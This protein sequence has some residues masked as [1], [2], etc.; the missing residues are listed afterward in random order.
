MSDFR[1][2]WVSLHREQNA[3]VPIPKYDALPDNSKKSTEICIIGGGIF[4]LSCALRLQQQGHQ[5]VLIEGRRIGS[6]TTGNSTGKLCLDHNKGKYQ[7][8]I[9]NFGV[10]HAKTYCD[11]NIEGMRFVRECLSKYEMEC[12]YEQKDNFTF[13]FTEEE[14][15]QLKR[16]VEALHKIGVRG[17]AFL[18]PDALPH[19]K[20]LNYGAMRVKR[21]AQMNPYGFCVKMA[22][23]FVKEGGVIHE[24]TRAVN[25]SKGAAP[26]TVTLSNGAEVSASKAVIV[27][28]HL[29]I[30]DRS[31][32]WAS[33][34]P[35]ASYGIA[36]PVNQKNEFHPITEMHINSGASGPAATKSFRVAGGGKYMVVVGSSHAMGEES[37]ILDMDPYDNLESFAKKY[38]NVDTDSE[39]VGKWFAFDYA[40][41]DDLGPYIGYLHLG[42]KSLF[43]ATGFNKWGLS[44]GAGASEYVCQLIEKGPDD[45][46]ESPYDIFDARRFD[47]KHSKAWCFG[48]NVARHFIGD[49]I[50]D[51]FGEHK[52]VDE[53]PPG[54]GGLY[55]YEN[56]TRACY[57]D[58]SGKLTVT[59]L[60]CQHLKCHVRY[61]RHTRSLCC[62][63]HGSH[64]N[65]KGEVLDAP[66]VK[67]LRTILCDIEDAIPCASGIELDIEREEETDQ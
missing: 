2:F 43:T 47:V 21:Q 24:K 56:V 10:K 48:L 9:C 41:S 4:G 37:E 51:R 40:P 49:R 53:L 1:S 62:P 8:L 16:E 31:A 45:K 30:L 59:D 14:A 34:S 66:T 52:H 50:A 60:S 20:F 18:E 27:A 12:D 44:F 38:L 28:T 17:V 25:V 67:N 46:S 6:A 36:F 55:K 32:H 13:A 11:M 58:Q 42:T 65:M 35:S 57:R 19:L 3:F 7:S 5:C 33:T 39:P 64:Y 26:H 29:P 15:E 54:Q 61:N 22:E 63:C 23:A